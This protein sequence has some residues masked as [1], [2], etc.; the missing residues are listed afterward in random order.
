MLEY[1]PAEEEKENI[2]NN[3]AA[4]TVVLT[5]KPPLVV[6]H[7]GKL[8]VWMYPIPDT[9]DLLNTAAL[10]TGEQTAVLVNVKG[11][12]I[13]YNHGGTTVLVLILPNNISSQ[14]R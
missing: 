13:S 5:N 8:S 2:P 1:K 10:G 9:V 6:A 3:K 4:D 11:V 14:A 7:G 12:I